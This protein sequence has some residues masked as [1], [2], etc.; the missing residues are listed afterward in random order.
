M[1][2]VPRDGKDRARVLERSFGAAAAA[3]GVAAAVPTPAARV[4]AL[5]G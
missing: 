5:L 3:L 4:G 1:Q 2:R